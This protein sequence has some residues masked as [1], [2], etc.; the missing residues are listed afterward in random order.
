MKRAL[1][2]VLLAG[3]KS[4]KC[5]AVFD[6]LAPMMEKE[7]GQKPDHD[8]MVGRCKD[9][10]KSDPAMEKALDCML[11]INGRPSVAELDKC[12][13]KKKSRMNEAELLLDKVGKNA[14]RASAET[15]AFPKGK[16]GLSPANECCYGNGSA[17]PKCP[18]DAKAWQDPVWQALEFEITEPSTYRYS[19]ESDGKTFTVLAVGDA[20]CDQNLATYTLTG[21]IDNG[22]ATTDLKKPPPGEY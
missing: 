14:K 15:G 1:I 4:D 21:K 12:A 11:A 10:L 2:I 22:A 19:Y 17:G 13:V 7:M 20:D 5:E 18:V 8:R 6:K 9:E 3:C 16:V